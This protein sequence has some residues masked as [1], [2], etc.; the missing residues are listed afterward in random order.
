MLMLCPPKVSTST[1]PAPASLGHLLTKLLVSSVGGGGAGGGGELTVLQA[2]QNWDC[3]QAAPL[4]ITHAVPAG[5]KPPQS[6][7]K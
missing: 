3:K 1:E 6:A 5:H 7:W 4:S 2:N